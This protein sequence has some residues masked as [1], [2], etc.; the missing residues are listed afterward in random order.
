LGYAINSQVTI[1]FLA[2]NMFN[3][4][5]AIRPARVDQPRNFNVQLRMSF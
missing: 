2:N 5:Y 3:R 4:E 1:A